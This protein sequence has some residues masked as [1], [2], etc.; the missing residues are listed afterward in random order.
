MG[1]LTSGPLSE[2]A[3]VLSKKFGI[4][5][6]VETGTFRGETTRWAAGR[7]EHVTTVEMNEQFYRE[8]CASLGDLPN[9]RVLHGDSV[10]VLKET[11]AALTGPAL[12]W[13]DAHSGGGFFAAEDYC[14]LIGELQAINASPL[15]HVILIDDAR[16]FL[17]PPPPPFKPEKWPGL[18]EVILT[19]NARFPTYTICLGDAIIA[20][21]LAAQNLLNQFSALVRPKI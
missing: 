6:F 15:Q 12:F 21:P 13:L 9:V 11:I 17:A 18:S 20:T 14:P 7:F 8:A 19:L 16:A 1:T 5:D 4:R 3:L 2:L 10:T